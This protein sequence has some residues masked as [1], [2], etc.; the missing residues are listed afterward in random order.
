LYP[1]AHLGLGRAAV[2]TGNVDEARKAYADFLALWN[3]ADS[4]VQPLK[5]ARAEYA[6]LRLR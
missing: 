6:R 2:A 3:G 4:S 1:L 5:Q